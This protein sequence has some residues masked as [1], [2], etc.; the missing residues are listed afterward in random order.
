MKI[1]LFMAGLLGL[2]SA[3]AFAQKGELSNAQSGYEKYEQLRGQK[4]GA[5][6]ITA[7][8]S[9]D[10]AKVSIDKASTNEKT[11]TLPLTFALKGAIYS[12]LAVK[13]TVPSTSA[14]LF[15]TA[16]EAIKKAKELDTKGENKKLIDASNLNL[17]QYKLSE[18]VKDYQSHS[19]DKAYTSFDYYRQIL[20]DDTNAIY[21]SALAASNAG[22]ADPGKY[23]PLAIEN[24]KRLVNTKYSGNAKAYFDMSTLY[25]LLKDTVN[26]LKSIEEGVAKYP[27]NNELRKRDIEIALQ[28]GKQGDILGKIEQAITND[29]K[30]KTLYYYAGLTYSQIADGANANSQKAKDAASANPLHQT[31][32]DNYA[33]ATDMY[34]KAIGIDPDYFEAN[35]NLGYVLVRP[36][37]DAYNAANKLPANK[38]KEYDDAI[39]K[40][41]VQFDVAKPYLLKAVEL[42]P[43]SV[44]A[45]TNLLSYYRGKKDNAN[46][47]KIKQ[48]IDALK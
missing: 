44:D 45:L 34:K 16:E 26:A 15:A 38:Q 7:N 24:Y 3:T 32:L 1:K 35:L 4:I 41:G 31:A 39:A 30:N 37:I 10:D 23:Y 8:K 21:Y 48:Q 29:P 40:A 43:K 2:V 13:D 22:S 11:A 25:I 47:A 17:A 5:I 14:P 27:S 36:A 28:S 6:A 19:Y 18:G 33:K 42:N 46:A 20:P 12:S 9:L